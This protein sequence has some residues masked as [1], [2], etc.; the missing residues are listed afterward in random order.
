MAKK[1][2]KE[3]KDC[4]A[5]G[6][7][8]MVHGFKSTMVNVERKVFKTIA[9]TWDGIDKEPCHTKK[10]AMEIA[11]EGMLG[12]PKD[13]VMKG[14]FYICL[15]SDMECWE[16]G[17]EVP[18]DTKIGA[19]PIDEDDVD[20]EETTTEETTVEETIME[21]QIEKRIMEIK[22]MNTTKTNNNAEMNNNYRFIRNFLIN[23]GIGKKYTDWNGDER[24][25]RSRKLDI[26]VFKTIN[27]DGVELELCHPTVIYTSKRRELGGELVFNAY[28]K[29]YGLIGS[30]EVDDACAAIFADAI[31]NGDIRSLPIETI[32]GNTDTDRCSKIYFSSIINGVLYETPIKEKLV[33]KNKQ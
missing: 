2:T 29:G 13:N 12:D 25:D 17:E 10:E 19:A 30:L 16:M 6:D 1:E 18:L 31:K 4:N 3:M 7:V 32:D 27:V 9:W 8:A 33:K 20:E 15:K 21:K 11:K 23:N 24:V 26:S 14:S 5:I 22:T 28:S